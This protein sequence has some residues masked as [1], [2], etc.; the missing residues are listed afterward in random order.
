M[1][2]RGRTIRVLCKCANKSAICF[3][4]L[5]KAPTKHDVI[6]VVIARRMHFAN[7]PLAFS[8]TTNE[9]PMFLCTIT[10]LFHSAR[11]PREWTAEAAN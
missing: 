5:V 8:Q 9:K 4:I 7:G 6:R 11:K 10:F 2:I 3:R 1:R